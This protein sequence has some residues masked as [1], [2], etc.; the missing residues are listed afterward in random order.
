MKFL[1]KYPQREFPYTRLVEENR[2]R[3]KHDLEFELID[4]G[5]F[6]DDRYFDVFIEY[7]NGGA[8]VFLQREQGCKR[9]PGG[10]GG[11]S[12]PASLVAHHLVLGP[13]RA[14][15]PRRDRRG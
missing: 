7:A 4:T 10:A 11:D 14:Q 6:D 12:A 1:Y 13:G 15:T 8:E 3:G 5:I 9:R 2:R